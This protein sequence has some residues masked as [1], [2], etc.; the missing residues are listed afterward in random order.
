MTELK[1]SHPL[2]LHFLMTE[3]IFSVD[4]LQDAAPA[5]T[6]PSTEK[7]EESMP[8]FDY[9]GENNRYMLLLHDNP[10]QK[11]MPSGELDT[12]TTILLAKKMEIKDVAI[13]NIAQYPSVT[14][15]QLKEYFACNS[16]VL[17]GV[18]PRRLQLNEIPQNAVTS[19]E[20][21]NVLFT[22]SFAEMLN[23]ND[24]KRAFWNEMKKL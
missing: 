14:W 16:L 8:V 1:T 23:N 24:R 5:V 21:M 2:A 10:N 3:D 4:E 9:Q 17:L 22:Y 20:G 12:L 7:E 18:T 19:F 11:L 6:A 15:R 13:V